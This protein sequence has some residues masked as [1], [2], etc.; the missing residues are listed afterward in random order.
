MSTTLAQAIKTSILASDLEIIGDVSCA[1]QVV[2]EAKIIGNVTADDIAIE[3]YAYVDGDVE[4]RAL[5]IEGVV[6][7]RVKAAVLT[8]TASGRISASISYGTLTVQPGG[9]V[10]G[11]VKKIAAVAPRA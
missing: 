9:S 5:K 1:G 10:E 3:A 6:L 8:V 7:G 11:L 2:I 4:A